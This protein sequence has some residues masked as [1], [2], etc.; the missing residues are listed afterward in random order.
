MATVIRPEISTKNKYWI[1]KHRHYELKHFCLQYPE[2]KRIYSAYDSSIYTS[3]I[4]RMP[5]SN[6]PSDP[7]LHIASL[8]YYYSERIEL[9]E[10]TAKAA[11]EY[12]YEY[13]LKAVT[14][15]LSYTYLRTKMD[16]P[17]SRDIY[18]DR[19]RKFFWLLSNSREKLSIL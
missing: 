12:L 19:Y 17:C 15:G 13:I 14:E 2:W 10:K 6:I 8:K 1:S 9:I 7:T 11:D 16:I 18:Y 4:D 5:T 3:I